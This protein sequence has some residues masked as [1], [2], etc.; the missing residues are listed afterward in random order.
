MKKHRSKRKVVYRPT[1]TGVLL[2]DPDDPAKTASLRLIGHDVRVYWNNGFAP[3]VIEE[4]AREW[5]P[6]AKKVI[7]DD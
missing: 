5:Y 3:E 2:K 4:A 6:V 7:F 1:T